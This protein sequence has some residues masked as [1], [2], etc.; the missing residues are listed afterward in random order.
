MQYINTSYTTYHNIKYKKSGHLFQGRYKSIVVDRD[1][2]L[3]TLS[4]YIHLNPVRAK[5]V[6]DPGEYRWTSYREYIEPKLRGYTDKERIKELGIKIGK[7]YEEFVRGGYR[8]EGSPLRNAYAGFILGSKEFIKDTLEE[9][10]EQKDTNKEVSYKRQIFPNIDVTR[11]IGVV[12]EHYG[13]SKKELLEGRRR[14]EMKEKK[15]AIYLL[16]RFTGLNNRGI[17]E[18]FGMKYA[19]VSK[20]G[21]TIEQLIEKDNEVKKEVARIISN[22]E[23]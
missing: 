16:R 23:V 2:Y 15:M 9:I 18:L 22:F 21:T 14:R 13:V 17:G 10:S 8:E 12:L 19:A 3:L 7:A 20:A 6:K 5:M 11:I 1:T 4:R